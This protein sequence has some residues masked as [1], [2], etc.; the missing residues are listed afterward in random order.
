MGKRSSFEIPRIDSQKTFKD[1][2]RFIRGFG[3]HKPC[4]V[5]LSGGIDSSLTAYLTKESVRDVQ[6]VIMPAGESQSTDYAIDFA[7]NHNIPY[8]IHDIGDIASTLNDKLKLE[9]KEARGNLQSRLRMSVLYGLANERKGLVIGTT[10]LSEFR[11]GYYTKYGDGGVDIEPIVQLYKTHVR[12]LSRD[13][14]IEESVIE[15]VPTAG[16]WEGQTDE[17]ELGISYEELDKILFL[18]DNGKVP[19]DIYILTGQ[20]IE[21]ISR[22]KSL[23]TISNHKRQMPYGGP[24]PFFEHG[25]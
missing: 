22:I 14:G 1:I 19:L 13:L 16:L 5:G 9:S 4:L 6:G 10:N 23:Q 11:L 2:T 7:E 24:K 15:R 3:Y 21:E 12:Q 25:L 20:P 17:N 8:E 18:Q